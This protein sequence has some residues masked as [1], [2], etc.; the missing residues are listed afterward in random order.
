LCLWLT[1]N[2]KESYARADIIVEEMTMG[3]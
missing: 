3:A 2:T 1:N